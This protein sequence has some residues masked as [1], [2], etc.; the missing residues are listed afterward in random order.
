MTMLRA[1]DA[2]I[3]SKSVGNGA[4]TSLSLRFRSKLF[5]PFGSVGK[6]FPRSH[7]PVNQTRPYNYGATPGFRKRHSICN[8]KRHFKW[9][10]G[11]AYS[12]ALLGSRTPYQRSRSQTPQTAPNNSNIGVLVSSSSSLSDRFRSCSCYPF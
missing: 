5:H 7:Y 9:V 8:C 6:H 1:A 12:V 10:S 11:A 4:I 2:R 3:P